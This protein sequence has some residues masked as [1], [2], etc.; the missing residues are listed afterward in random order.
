MTVAPIARLCS[1]EL[2]RGVAHRIECE[3]HLEPDWDPFAATKGI[4]QS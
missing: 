1:D 2:A 4:I 3:P